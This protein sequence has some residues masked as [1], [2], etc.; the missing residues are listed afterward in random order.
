MAFQP[1]TPQTFRPSY[2]VWWAKNGLFSK[3]KF[4]VILV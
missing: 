4:V 3:V 2:N 1:M